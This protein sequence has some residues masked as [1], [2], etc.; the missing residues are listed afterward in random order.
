MCLILGD[1]FRTSL[2]RKMATF[3]FQ[4]GIMFPL[5]QCQLPLLDMFLSK[6][7]E[8]ERKKERGRERERE[9]D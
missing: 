3:N 5:F 2:F 7:R 6:E 1:C 9:R 8:R 4:T